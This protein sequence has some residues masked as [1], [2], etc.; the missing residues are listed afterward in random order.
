[1]ALLE[2]LKCEVLDKSRSAHGQVASSRELDD[3]SQP[4]IVNEDDVDAYDEEEKVVER[5]ALD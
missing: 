4:L 2:K 3:S 1:M 5:L